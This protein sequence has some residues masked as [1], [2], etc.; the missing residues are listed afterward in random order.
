MSF[1]STPAEIDTKLHDCSNWMGDLRDLLGPKALHEIWFPGVGHSSALD[2]QLVAD[3]LERGV[4]YLN[5]RLASNNLGDYYLFYGNRGSTGSGG[6]RTPLNEVL[7]AGREFLDRH[8]H[9]ILIF[10]FSQ[11]FE[12]DDHSLVK[13]IMDELGWYAIP[14]DRGLGVRVDALWQRGER[15]V[16]TYPSY[17]RSR[18][19][20]EE[21]HAR[22]WEPPRTP[23]SDAPDDRNSFNI[24]TA[25]ADESPRIVELCRTRNAA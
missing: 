11:V 13:R 1:P 7:E 2:G 23:L 17:R 24:V 18:V 3:Q 9:E 16:I 22:L 14:V 10:D 8:S 20:L 6:A 5:F 15:A 21:Y 4:R 25:G 12:V 19:R